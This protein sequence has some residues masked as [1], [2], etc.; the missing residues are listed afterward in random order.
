[1][2]QKKFVFLQLSRYVCTRRIQFRLQNI[3]VVSFLDNVDVV[4]CFVSKSKDVFTVLSLHSI[5]LFSAFTER[6]TGRL[7]KC[8]CDKCQQCVGIHFSSR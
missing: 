3:H 6:L 1:M 2:M 5:S 4:C 8:G 7:Y